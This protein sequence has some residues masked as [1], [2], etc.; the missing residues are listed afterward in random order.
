MTTLRSTVCPDDPE[1]IARTVA[2]AVADKLVCSGAPTFTADAL[3]EDPELSWRDFASLGL[4]SVDWMNVATALEEVLGVEL[5]D[6]MLL[7]A[8]SRSVAGWS[9]HLHRLCP[10]DRTITAPYVGELD[11]TAHHQRGER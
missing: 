1:Q 6:E 10:P 4:N 2:E 11:G 7:D 9:E 3:L 5:P 8:G